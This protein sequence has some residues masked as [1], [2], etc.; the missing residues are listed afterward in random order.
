MGKR[1]VKFG[2][3]KYEFWEFLREKYWAVDETVSTYT[4]TKSMIKHTLHRFKPYVNR[5]AAI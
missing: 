5:E 1:N 3:K 2:S 4:C